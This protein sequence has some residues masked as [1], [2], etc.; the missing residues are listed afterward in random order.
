MNRWLKKCTSQW[1]IDCVFCAWRANGDD[2][3]FSSIEYFFNNY[4][5]CH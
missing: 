4:Y 5:F 3:V 1:S 2:E